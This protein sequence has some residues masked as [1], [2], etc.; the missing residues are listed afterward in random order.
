MIQL[1]S[2][3]EQA[4][5]QEIDQQCPGWS[6]D[7]HWLF[8]RELL[9]DPSIRDVCVLGV[10]HGRDIAYIANMLQRAKRASYSIT[11][12]DLFADT[13]GADWR[14]EQRNLTWQQAGFGPAPDLARTA[15]NLSRL[16]LKGQVSLQ[17]ADARDFLIQV[18][19]TYDL[20][21]VDVSHDYATTKEMIRLSTPRLREDGILGGD[22]F[23]NQG[24]W[25]VERAV[26]ESFLQ[27]SLFG[28]WIWTAKLDHYLLA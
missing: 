28:G 20:I 25:G 21:Y 23:S 18:G 5:K 22:D 24:T 14:E 7:V 27:F 6:S 8:F 3:D 15:Q 1:L 10:C 4:R 19:M 16:G 13:P 2:A 9:S 17:K 12:I 26:R 11:G